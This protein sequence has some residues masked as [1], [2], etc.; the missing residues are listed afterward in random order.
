MPSIAEVPLFPP[1]NKKRRLDDTQDMSAS[2]NMGLEMQMQMKLA[3]RSVSHPFRFS[4]DMAKLTNG[5]NIHSPHMTLHE[6][7]AVFNAGRIYE[8]IQMLPMPGLRRGGDVKRQRVE[9][10]ALP[11]EEDDDDTDLGTERDAGCAT[12]RAENRLPAKIDLSPCHICHRKPTVR[13]EL[14]GFADC[15][16]CG[17]RT[18]YICIRE[19]EGLRVLQERYD[20]YGY[21]DALALS[22]HDEGME[23]MRRRKR[24]ESEH[25]ADEEKGVGETWHKGRMTEH[26]RMVC[27]R[28]CV[29]RGTEGEV[30][31]LGCLKRAEE[32]G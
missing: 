17:R 8:R 23:D 14:S 31:C 7:G 10:A 26:R 29:E 13:A 19:C 30:W 5:L 18:C 2:M 21:Y 3:A 6:T 24:T 25:D 20:D 4:R 9:R 27:S 12:R 15:E 28:C 11:L 32:I 22:P 1:L 16:G